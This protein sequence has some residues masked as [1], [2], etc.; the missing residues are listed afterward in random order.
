MRASISRTLALLI[1]CAA[2]ASAA[3]FDHLPSD[4]ELL[5]R[6]DLVVVGTVRRAASRIRPDNGWV[7]TDYELAGEETLKGAAGGAITLAGGGGGGGG[8]IP[9]KG[10]AA[11]FQAPARGLG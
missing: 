5:G 3:V 11:A 6:S 4:A 2:G 1:V 7:V 10:R 9:P 8:R